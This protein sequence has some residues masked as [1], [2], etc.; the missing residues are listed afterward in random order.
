MSKKNRDAELNE[1][2]AEAEII[3]Q[4]ELD[5][6]F[7]DPSIEV[8][9][10]NLPAKNN[11]EVI[12]HKGTSVDAKADF[13]YVRENLY[14]AIGTNQRAIQELLKFAKASQSPRA[15]EVIAQLIRTL[16]EANDRL[17]DI[18]RKKKELEQQGVPTGPSS[19]TNNAIFV[20]KTADLDDLISGA[21]K[22]ITDGR[23]KE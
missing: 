15:Y 1:I 5:G 7:D 21:L 16:N 12:E 13:E 6:I 2:L 23:D 22:K 10:E 19:V 11:T 18:H 14:D 4:N 17:L 3:E 9:E 20:G 8:V